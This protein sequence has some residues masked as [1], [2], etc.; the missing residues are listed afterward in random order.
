MSLFTKLKQTH[1]H[2]KQTSWLPK[3]R[4]KLGVWDQQIQ[5]TIYKIDEQQ[6]P[7]CIA[8]GTIF[9]IL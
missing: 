7:T 8:Q 9:N 2:I 6:G 1:R 4:A 5:A 3:W